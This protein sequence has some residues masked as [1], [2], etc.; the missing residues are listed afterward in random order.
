MP[1]YLIHYSSEIGLKGKNR[2]DFISQLQRNIR[3]QL[4][5]KQVEHLMGRLLVADP[6]PEVDFSRVFG[7]AW[8]ASVQAGPPDMAWILAEAVAQAQRHPLAGQKPTFAVRAKR[9][10]KTFPSTSEQIQRQVGAAIVEA[11]GWPVN[12]REPQVVIHV[13]V[14]PGRAFVFSQRHPGYQGL[15]VGISGKVVGLYS[16]GIDS[17]IAAW[18]MARRGAQ[19]T[20]VHF[21]AFVDAQPAH[22][23]KAGRLAALLGAY[24]PGLQVHYVPY[25][26]FQ[27]ATAGLERRDQR[28]EL[29][30]F[31]RF[32]A[33]A[34][35]RIAQRV[36]ARAIFT[37]DSLGQVASQTLENMTAVDAAVQIPIFRP[38]IAWNKQEIID[39]GER[40]GF[41]EVAK[42]PYKDCC[43]IISTHPATRAKLPVVERMEA[44]LN[45]ESLLEES[46]RQAESVRYGS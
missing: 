33:R 17:A 2:R 27:I 28:Y 43:S 46:L 20:L 18:L 30:T 40:L 19:V 23:G 8:W 10:D 13:E 3:R 25:Y 15:P 1:V 5:V 31:R 14:A 26:P 21:H 29:V 9:A 22:Q 35:E 24:I 41:Y 6:R 12:L 7:V 44:A 34:A 4:G 42:E 38:L 36:G 39:L 11:L 37:G 45:L 32:M 16:G